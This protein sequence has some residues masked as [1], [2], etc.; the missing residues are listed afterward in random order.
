MIDKK[1]FKEFLQQL[2]FSKN[3]DTFSKHFTEIGTSLKVDFKSEKLIYPE[4]MD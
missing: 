3:G 2:G 4:I 1:N